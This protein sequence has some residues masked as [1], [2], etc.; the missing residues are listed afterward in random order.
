MSEGIFLWVHCG[1]YVQSNLYKLFLNAF[2]DNC[3]SVHSR[4][5]DNMSPFMLG[6]IGSSETTPEHQT[7]F[8]INL[9]FVLSI[10]YK[11]SKQISE[12]AVYL[13]SIKYLRD[14]RAV[15]L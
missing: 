13:C 6:Y 5:I 10:Y 9:Q 8:Q 12:E 4:S 7:L 14:V 11:Y 15:Y 3:D 2:G 1:S